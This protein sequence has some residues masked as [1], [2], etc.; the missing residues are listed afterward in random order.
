MS[1]TFGRNRPESTVWSVSQITTYIREMFEVDFRLRDVLLEGEI[2]NFRP[3]RSGHLYFTLKDAGAQI[4]CV[5]WRSNAE[6]LIFQPQDGDAVRATGQISVYEAGGNYQLIASSL[7]P[8]G[9]GNLALAFERLK[10]RLAAEGLFDQAHKKPLPAFPARLGIVTSA[11]AAALRDILNVLRRRYPL[12]AVLIAPTLVQGAEAPP[13][14]I[15]ALQ[16]LDGRDDIDVIILARGGGS[17][18]DLWAFNDEGVARAIFAAR[19]P[20]ISGIGHE[21]D[22]TIADFVADVRAP[23]PS[24]A[25]EL[26]TPDSAELRAYIAGLSGALN[27]RLQVWL[28]QRRRS[29]QSAGRALGHLS[30]QARI[31]NHTQRL[32]ELWGRLNH[33]H[34]LTWQQRRGR[35]DVAEARLHAVSP[36]ATLARGYAIVRQA[37][38]RIVH[39]AS[40]VSPGERL[41]AQLAEGQ[42]SLRVEAAEAV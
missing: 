9:R 19:H 42:L 1:F 15:R 23:T 26:A 3:A 8:T 30:P 27:H 20:V 25:A 39:Q 16:W 4:S 29:L 32:D 5:M 35:L 28:D 36:L 6:R 34:T 41:T 22:F 17:L 40:Q 18:E 7:L 2:S 14:I 21:V 33:A 10:Q 38:G 13:Q 37:D 31:R 11:D 12:A 24:A